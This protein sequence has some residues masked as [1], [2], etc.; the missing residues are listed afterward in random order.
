MTAQH[1]SELEDFADAVLRERALVATGLSVTISDCRRPDNPLVWINPAF[2][3]TT[4]YDA[5]DAVG[6]NCRFLQGPGTDRAVVAEIREC[7]RSGQSFT[8]TVLNYRKD[9]SRFW[10]EMTISPVRDDFGVLTHHVGVQADVTDRVEAQQAR[11]EALAQAARAA[12]RLSLLADYTS[13]MAM[14]RQPQQVLEL[15]AESVVP[16]VGTWCAVWTADGVKQP[17][18][19]YALHERMDDPAVRG[20]LDQLRAVAVDQLHPDSPV[21]RV[22][23]GRE[24][25]VRIP[26]YD[27]APAAL[28]GAAFD[29]RTSLIYQLGI[30][31]LIVVPLL[32]RGGILGCVGLAGGS[33]RP[34]FGSA[35]L[36]LARDL[37][38]R[39]G[40][41]LENT[42]LFA[43]ERAAAST[44]QRSLL[45]RLPRLDG[46]EVA[47]A[48]VP[49][50]DEVAV[51]GDWY[52]VFATRQDSVGIVVGDVM[53]HNMDSAAR[54]GKLSTVLRA[55][56]WPGND[57]HE[58]FAAVDELLAGTEMTM[59]A[60][61]LYA[62]VTAHPGGATLR[63]SSAG[64]PPAIVRRAD[65]SAS[66]LAGGAGAMLGISRL[67]PADAIRPPDAV[68]ELQPG[69]TLVCFTDGLVDAMSD[70]QDTDA[71][72]AQMCAVIAQLPLA[73]APQDIVDALTGFG[74]RHLDDIAVV[75]LRIA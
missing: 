29:D 40:L 38:V 75:A 22:L 63:Y 71:G 50:V 64:H 56:A 31:S 27:A 26:D 54:M 37:S 60:T 8:K 13:R 70:E 59:F 32:A 11:D 72:L 52:D 18:L 42:Q 39:A 74:D 19:S 30:R 65:G 2:T 51:G 4:G 9:G 44:L 66:T 6:R 15:L 62:R 5:A 43:R 14:C 61:C 36:T 68:V 12:D 17:T 1:A 28:T 67:L 55:Y 33:D 20:L 10:N 41:M 46:V 16:R 23:D 25:H 57:P 24:P 3:A 21:L 45:P 34:A 53:G 69:A 58:V 7:L 35:D 73:A 48:Y 49:A 47:A